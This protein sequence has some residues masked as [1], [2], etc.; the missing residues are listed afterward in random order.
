MGN[1]KRLFLFCACGE[2][3]ICMPAAQYNQNKRT[4]SFTCTWASI[5]KLLIAW[6]LLYTDISLRLCV[7]QTWLLLLHQAVACST[8]RNTQ[9]QTKLTGWLW[10]LELAL[11]ARNISIL[12]SQFGLVCCLWLLPVWNSYLMPWF[13]VFRV[14]RDAQCMDMLR[15]QQRYKPRKNL[16]RGVEWEEKTNNNNSRLKMYLPAPKPSTSS[17]KTMAVIL[18]SSLQLLQL[19]RSDFFL[20]LLLLLFHVPFFL[21]QIATMIEKCTCPF[22]FIPHTHLT[23]LRERESPSKL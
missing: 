10:R 1:V 19:R 12:T 16:N 4:Q 20:L 23:N 18:F 2:C 6:T 17:T 9:S 15:Q 14:R 11:V 21:L 13:P 3:L 7:R 8:L 22:W 5:D